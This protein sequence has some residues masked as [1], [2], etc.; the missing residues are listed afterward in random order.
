MHRPGCRPDD[1]PAIGRRELLHVG[2][3]NLF[4][5][6]LADL[7]RLEAPAAPPVAGRGLGP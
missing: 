5:A 3:L 2:A 7:L 1:H 6:G 4:G